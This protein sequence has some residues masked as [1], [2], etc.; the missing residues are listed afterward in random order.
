MNTHM[1]ETKC[2]EDPKIPNRSIIRKCQIWGSIIGASLTAGLL[3][4]NFSVSSNNYGPGLLI[5]VISA[6]SYPLL[7]SYN[8]LGFGLT[9]I[10][11]IFGS[12][13]LMLANVASYSAIATLVGMVIKS[14]K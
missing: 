14:Q 11:P 9:Q 8:L 7:V 6:P 13:L 10:N 5:G 2:P 1:N 4:L 12:I 3:I